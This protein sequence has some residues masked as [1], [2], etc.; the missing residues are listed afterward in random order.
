MVP[1][2]EKQ[3]CH[4]RPH[5]HGID[6]AHGAVR[7]DIPRLRHAGDRPEHPSETAVAQRRT[8]VR[9]GSVRP[10]PVC[11][12]HLGLAYLAV[13]GILHRRHRHVGGQSH[14]RV[15]RLLRR[16]RRQHPHAH[17]GR[18]PC[19]ARHDHGRRHRRR[20]RPRHHQRADGDEHLPYPAVCPY[21]ALG[22]HLHPQSGIR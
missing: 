17:H 5:P 12:R 14:R 7:G 18:V 22:D 10:R 6:A 2:Q 19:H 16:P 11:A 15:C 4:V 9:H 3:T 8:L 13:R 1:V 20:A 21:R